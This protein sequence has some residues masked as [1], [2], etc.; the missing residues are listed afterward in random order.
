MSTPSK[1]FVVTGSSRGI[2]LAIAQYL[3]DQSCRVVLVAR[4]EAPLRDLER[5]Y[6]D[7]V[8][9]LIGDFSNLSLGAKVIAVA[10]EKWQRLDGLI[11]N[12]GVLDPV[13]RIADSNI[14]EWHTA[15][16]INFLSGVALAQAAIPLL[17]RSKG[18]II[19]T[20]SGAAVKSYQGWGAYGSAKAA[21]N[22]LAM[23]LGVEEQDI[24][25]FAIRPGLVDTEIQRDIREKHTGAMHEKDSSYFADL[26]ASGQL[27]K[28]EGPGHVM[29][30]LA[31]S[32]PK[33]LS[34]KFLSWNDQEL[35]GY[36]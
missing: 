6:G 3:L 28:P 20:S 12:H 14:N 21:M 17:R 25:S 7:R 16:N 9:V 30:K 35:S 18:A 34:G 27:V 36:S 4:S 26:K 23:T 15:F 13:A 24:V 11:I 33:A 5:R 1:V 19:F 22:H 31:L 8:A 29:A 2:G 10:Q 32:P